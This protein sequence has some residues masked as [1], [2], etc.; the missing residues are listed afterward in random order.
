[1]T[2]D[3]VDHMY[4]NSVNYNYIVALN[5]ILAKAGSYRS[6]SEGLIKMAKTSQKSNSQSMDIN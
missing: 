3:V 5:E 2:D 6:I 1:M 4:Q